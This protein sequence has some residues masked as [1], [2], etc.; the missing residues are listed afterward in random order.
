MPPH[1]AAIWDTDRARGLDEVTLLQRE[2]LS[3]N[4]PRQPHPGE[5]AEEYDHR[6]HRAALDRE[7]D[8]QQEDGG[9]GENHVDEAHQ[10][11]VDPAAIVAGQRSNHD[12]EGSRNKR[13][14]DADEQR[15]SS[16]EHEAAQF[17]T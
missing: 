11:R 8:E 4:D 16:P 7:K 10:R 12:T 1:Q 3:A 9:K 2:K 5:E 14:A 13:G 15:Y 17:V 6:Q